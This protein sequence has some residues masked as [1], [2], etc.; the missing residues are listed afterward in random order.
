MFMEW[1]RCI[2]NKLLIA[3]MEIPCKSPALHP[4]W[5]NDGESS[6][7]VLPYEIMGNFFFY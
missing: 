3:D 6:H 1:K 2:S 5:V 7:W 4:L